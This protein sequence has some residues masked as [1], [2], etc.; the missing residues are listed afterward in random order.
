MCAA[1]E[2]RRFNGLCDTC[3]WFGHLSC[4]CLLP[5]DRIYSEGVHI[6]GSR[7]LFTKHANGNYVQAT[8]VAHDG[9]PA[10]C[11]NP[12]MPATT[13][14]SA[15]VPPA[16]A[17]A[18]LRPGATTSADINEL[19]V[20]LGHAHEGN[21]RETAKQMGIRVTGTLVP[22]SECAAAK[23]VRRFVRRSLRCYAGL[24]RRVGLLLLHRGLLLQLGVA[25][26][27]EG[28]IRRHRHPR[29]PRL[30][31]GHQATAKEARGAGSPPHRQRDE[32]CQRTFCQPF[33]SVQHPPRVHLR[34]R[35]EAQRSRGAANRPGKGRNSRSMVG[36]SASLPGRTVSQQGNTLL[37][38][39]AGGMDMGVGKYPHHFARGQPGQEVPGRETARQTLAQTA[40]AVPGAGTP[41][42]GLGS[43]VGR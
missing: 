40:T 36:V 2:P 27:P 30:S 6:L 42:P 20:S 23:G 35:A 12:G 33:G 39:V 17:A 43:Q 24:Y 26:I 4:D 13:V 29:L 18:V 10:V 9:S 14:L 19:D 31:G 16:M 38:R 15:T 7:I 11:L 34:R 25:D 28:Q 3:C 41:H 22:C 8:K 32:I 1:R 5:H 37:C 21:L